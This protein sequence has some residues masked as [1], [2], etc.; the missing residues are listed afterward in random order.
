MDD[1]EKTYEDFGEMEEKHMH[2]H[3]RLDIIKA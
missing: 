3:L 1:G 2:F